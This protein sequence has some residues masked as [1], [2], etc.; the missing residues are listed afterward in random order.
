MWECC[1]V[2]IS[3][4][5][6]WLLS[7]S[8]A[9]TFC[10]GAQKWISSIIRLLSEIFCFFLWFWFCVLINLVHKSVERV[11][12]HKMGVSLG[13]HTQLCVIS[14]DW[15]VACWGWRRN[16]KR[17]QTCQQQMWRIFIFSSLPKRG[18]VPRS[19]VASCRWHKYFTT[20]LKNYQ[21][22]T[23]IMFGTC[24]DI[25][26]LLKTFFSLSHVVGWLSLFLP[27][28]CYWF[29]ALSSDLRSSR[30]TAGIVLKLLLSCGAIITSPMLRLIL[31]SIL[32]TD[33]ARSTPTQ[34]KM[35][36]VSRQIR[37]IILASRMMRLILLNNI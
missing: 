6:N 34:P 30:A 5:I 27:I 19:L 10:A 9:L 32:W 8:H 11:L 23:P 7:C 1:H 20:I 33:F 3:G 29:F 25:W 17:I 37:L 13:R 26:I 2:M 24:T 28:E 21:L 4:N 15:A 18:N 36:I 22:S 14:A 31:H 35:W 12:L 16:L